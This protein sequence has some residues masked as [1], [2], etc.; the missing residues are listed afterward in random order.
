MTFKAFNALR[1]FTEIARYSSFSVAAQ[2]LH[3]TK[4]AISYQIAML[5]QQLGFTV[6]HRQPRG[7]ALTKAGETLLNHS[8]STFRDLS[9]VITALGNRSTDELTVGMSSYFAAR[10]LSPRLMS[11]MQQYPQITLKLQP[12][13]DLQDFLNEGI[14]MVI[15]WGNGHWP[16]VTVE[17]LFSSPVRAYAGRRVAEQVE[18]VGLQQA[19]RTTPLLQDREG[20][21]AWQLWHQ[22]AGINYTPH[23]GHLVIPDPSVRLQAVIDGQGM[24]L[25]DDLAIAEQTAGTLVP[26]SRVQLDDFGYYLI[27]ADGALDNSASEQ[28][29]QWILQL[30]RSG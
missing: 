21:K 17:N 22:N 11:F 7:I 1:L 13:I 25:Y 19:L 5:E 10:W 23:N 3:M 30:A 18:A 4:G 24:A 14:D 29:R 9:N 2:H 27:Y 20:S 12:M 8:S 16:G 26:V 28:F 15:R 6:F